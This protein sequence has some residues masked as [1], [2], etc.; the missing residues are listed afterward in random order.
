[1]LVHDVWG[2]CS[3]RVVTL[4]VNMSGLKAYVYANSGAG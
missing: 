3:I 1:M 2:V 4:V